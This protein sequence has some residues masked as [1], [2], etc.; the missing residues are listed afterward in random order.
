ME[1][2]GSAMVVITAG[3]IHEQE[4]GL[5]AAS[6]SKAQVILGMASQE[7][8]SSQCELVFDRGKRV[9]NRSKGRL[10]KNQKRLSHKEAMKCKYR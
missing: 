4:A 5:D 8:H 1:Q 3:E 10:S 9:R 6:V 7:V 2:D